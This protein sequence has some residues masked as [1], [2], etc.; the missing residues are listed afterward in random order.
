M[1]FIF[2]IVIK[3]IALKFGFFPLIVVDVVFVLFAILKEERL[4]MFDYLSITFGL[5]IYMNIL[6]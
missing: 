6:Y 4:S 1:L 2:K 3:A 5:L